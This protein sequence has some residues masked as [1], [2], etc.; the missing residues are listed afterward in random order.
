[1]SNT[2]RIRRR[3]AGGA[4]GAPSSLANA[5]LAYNEQ[6]DTLYYGWGTGGS[7]GS[8]TGV[9]AIAGPGAFMTVS[10]AQTIS[11]NKTFTGSVVVN[12]PVNPQDAATKSYVDARAAGLDPKASVKCIATSNITLSGGA[13]ITVIDGYIIQNGSRVAVVGQ[14]NP[15]ENGVYDI[16]GSGAWTRS[17]DFVT[18]KV[19]GGAHFFVE[20]GTQWKGTGWTLMWTSTADPVVG[21][22]G[23]DFT[24]FSGMG[25]I[26]VD[27]VQLTKSGNTLGIGTVAVAHGGTGAADA[28]GARSNLGVPSV[29]GGGATGSWNISINGSALLLANA[30]WFSITGGSSGLYSNI[31]SFNGSGDV[32][33]A[34]AGV[35][36]LANGGT[37]ATTAANARSNLG[38]GTMATQ[39][40]D[41][42]AITGGSISGVTID[43]VTIDGGTY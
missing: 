20:A 37:G 16:P 35:L 25:D 31:T 13:G 11:G 12:D 9:K 14:T 41:A 32:S 7:G 23:L 27:G 26:A 4:G 8:A 30:R 19:T 33:L 2:I 21:T 24:Q 28:A 43:N 42:V 34:I 3:A 39:A 10:T 17:A 1:M 15:A 22:D 18:G 36:A 40:A 5:E 6:D 29:S 38:L